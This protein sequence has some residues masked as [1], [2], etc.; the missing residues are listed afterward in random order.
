M[1]HLSKF[2]LLAV[3]T[4]SCTS[5]TTNNVAM[6]TN[7]TAVK[8]TTPRVTGIGGIFFKSKNVKATKDWYGKHLGLVIDQYGS[9]FEVRNA[10]NPEEI[11]YLE[12]SVF[13]EKTN[14][15]EPSTKEFMINYRV[16]NN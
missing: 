13:S 7:K 11:N 16:Q 10:N 1:K 3:V 4:A 12:W 6:V 5:T 2:I 9:P 14:Y 15:F 8:D